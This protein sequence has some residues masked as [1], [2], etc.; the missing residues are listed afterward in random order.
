MTYAVVFILTLILSASPTN[1]QVHHDL[2]ETATPRMHLQARVWA[3]AAR[4]L[5]L[6]L[7]AISDLAALTC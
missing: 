1:I 7:L 6:A 4:V 2:T 3:A 5:A